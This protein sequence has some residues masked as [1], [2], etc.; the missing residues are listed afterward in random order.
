[1]KTQKQKIKVT[2]IMLI[3]VCNAV[4]FAE[5]LGNAFTYQGRLLDN[6]SAANG[7]YDMQFKLY[8]DPNVLVGSPIG[9]TLTN[10]DVEVM[11]GY[12]IVE[13]DFGAGV[14]NGQKRY[15]Q[16]EIR[17]YDSSD[18][19]DYVALSPLQNLTPTPYAL[20]A[21]TV[22]SSHSLD[23]ADGSPSDVVYV[24]EEG[25]VGIGITNPDTKLHIFRESPSDI[26]DAHLILAGSEQTGAS[27]TG[28]GLKFQGHDGTGDRTWC[29]IRGLK[30]NSTVGD[31]ASYMN[32]YTRPSAGD[33]VERM[34]IDSA[35]RVGI[36]TTSPTAP[37]DIANPESGSVVKVG[38]LTGYPSIEARSNAA[39]GWLILDSTG[40]GNVGLNH[41][42]DGDVILA[43]GGGNVGIGLSQPAAKLHVYESSTGNYGKLGSTSYGGYGYSS[44]SP[45]LWGE[46]GSS[47]GIYGISNNTGVYGKN[48][49]SNNFG[50]LGTIEY[51]VSGT[52]SVSGGSGVYGIS[53]HY[54]SG[55][56]VYGLH[57][58]SD[59]YGYLGGISMG[60]Y[61]KH[62]TSENYGL[63]GSA[64]YGA[65][66]KHGSTGNYGFLGSSSYG[67]KGYG[68][69]GNIGVY[70]ESVGSYGV[71]GYSGNS[72]G[73]AGHSNSSNGV[74][75]S[76]VTGYAGYFDGHVYVKYDVSAQSFTDRT[77]YP[78][79]LQTAYNAIMSMER[80]PDGHYNEDDKENQLD[81]SKLSSFIRSSDG[82][83]DLSA[84]VSCLNEVVKDLVRK[85]E[86]QQHLIETQNG[87]IQ[88]LT[89]MLQTNNTLKLLSKGGVQ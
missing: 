3:L 35:G 54:S 31:H 87:Q 41:Y 79:D 50:Q 4:G 22:V 21:E 2:I 33:P 18:P 56:G 48:G 11:D 15:L 78:K 76:S 19:N 37:L 64:L 88:K 45:G 29:N 65:F 67:V 47:S 44:S 66:A 8:D 75:G 28:G 17:P 13:L 46:S 68:S 42:H 80:L 71:S 1:M 40:D 59:N 27:D 34:R 74:Y 63:L 85:V 51:G 16:T 12:F 36:G 84:T 61:G 23:A 53:T 32:F 52:S 49:S 55:N 73:V 10:E 60:V 81:H 38:R 72:Y 86:A 20:Y 26:Y 89:E 82:N 6:N 62:N 77:P 58:I 83:R 7:Y 70:G 43:E 25:N 30:E 69:S 14:F 57:S 9:P 24:D 5:P 39:G